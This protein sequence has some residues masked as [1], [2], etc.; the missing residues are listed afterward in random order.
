MNQVRNQLKTTQIN[1]TSSRKKTD[2][3]DS[4]NGT[5]DTIG[6]LANHPIL[7]SQQLEANQV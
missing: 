4:E 6:Y 2:S 1:S 7:L 5:A 3:A